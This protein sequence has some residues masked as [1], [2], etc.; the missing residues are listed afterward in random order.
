MPGQYPNVNPGEFRDRVTIEQKSTAR[1]ATGAEIPVWSA[2]RTRDCKIEPVGGGEG[3][4]AASAQ[5]QAVGSHL[6]RMWYT[7]G[8]Q[9]DIHRVVA[10]AP[11]AAGGPTGVGGGRVFD[12][13]AVRDNME[14]RTQTILDCREAIGAN[15]HHE[16][17]IAG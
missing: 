14:M 13:L 16:A 2:W 15:V 6:I 11:G 1:D 9:P 3:Y 17:A 12:I 5:V 7:A 8:I 10:S 4:N